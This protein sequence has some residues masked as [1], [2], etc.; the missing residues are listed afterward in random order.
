[1][2]ATHFHELTLLSE[3]HKNVQNVHVTT[4]LQADSTSTGLTLLYKIAPGCCSKSFGIHVAELA[5]FP[6]SV[7]QMAKAK[8]KYLESHDNDSTR[9]NEDH[10]K[11]DQDLKGILE[12]L[13]Q[14]AHTSELD[15][16]LMVEKLKQVVAV[17]QS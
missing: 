10:R 12:Q 6:D 11:S 7:I 3:H 4:H 5:R 8:L 15:R 17:L 9:H 1:M 13:R 2:F 14:A 16:R